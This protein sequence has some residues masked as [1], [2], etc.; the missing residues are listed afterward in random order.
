[1]KLAS[2]YSLEDPRSGAVRYVGRTLKSSG[3]RLYQHIRDARLGGV[4]HRVNWIRSLLN[5]GIEPIIRIRAIVSVS[6]AP[7]AERLLI[8]GLRKEGARLVNSTDGGEGMEGYSHTPETRAKLSRARTGKKASVETRTKMSRSQIKRFEKSEEREKFLGR[9]HS[10][11]SI[12]KMSAA[13]RGHKHTPEARAKISATHKGYKFTPEHRANLSFA[14]RAF[15]A[16]GG[17]K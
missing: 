15:W 4:N 13:H 12:A 16:A 11:E 8:R 9:R 1:M 7:E 2:I 5:I 17:V 3:G 14:M 10:V 6:S